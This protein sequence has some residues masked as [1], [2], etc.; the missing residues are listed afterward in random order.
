MKVL[1]ATGLAAQL[2]PLSWAGNLSSDH[3]HIFFDVPNLIMTPHMSG[4]F[5][6]YWPVLFK[7]VEQNLGHFK[8][9]RALLNTVS[10]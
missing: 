4:V 6:A 5:S 9:D 10:R 8:N 3:P 1:M 2:Q 7:L